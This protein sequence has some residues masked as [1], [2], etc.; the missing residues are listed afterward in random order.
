MTKLETN[1]VKIVKHLE[2][3]G[4]IALFAG[5]Y[6]RDKILKRATKDIDIA[7]NAK[8][9]E[10]KKV[11][12]KNKI[13]FIEIG[14]AFGVIAAVVPK[15]KKESYIYEIATFRQDFGSID[16]RHPKK[17]KLINDPKEDAVRRDFT[18]NG[19]FLKDGKVIDYV[20]GLADIKAKVIRFIGNPN[21]RIREDALRMLRAIRFASTLNFDIEKNSYD[22]IVKNKELI[23]KVSAERVREELTK[24][25]TSDNKRRGFEQLE[26]TGLLNLII[27]ELSNAKLTPQPKNY[28]YEGNVWNHILLGLEKSRTNDPII[29]WAI[30]L[31]DV[32]KAFTLMMPSKGSGDRIRFNG[33]DSEGAK[34]AERILRRLKF[35]NDEIN[36]IT[37]MIKFHMLFSNLF[38]MREAR[39]I[40]YLA[41]PRFPKLLELFWVDANSSVRSTPSGRVLPPELSAYNRGKKF[42]EAENNKPRLPKPLIRGD[43]VMKIM[44]ITHG[45][46]IVGE[47]LSKVYDAQLEKRVKTKS[48]AKKLAEKLLKR[49]PK[50]R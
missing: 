33:H 20:N 25:L 11:L 10:I 15:T 30:L 43:V 35:G 50:I 23:K 18:I 45:N 8:P 42:L 6:V 44:G 49:H 34:I 21:E 29:N 9:E 17:I 40:M 36:T 13:K 28:H 37:W 4:Y 5:G 27:P 46:K 22:A 12:T 24:I 39:R 3:A 1:A 48:E 47:I 14:E 38:K 26:K 41:D 19:L 7:T 2:S 16:S 32:G 31:H